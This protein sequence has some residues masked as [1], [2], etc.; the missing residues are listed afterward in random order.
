[1][2]RGLPA[3]PGGLAAADEEATADPA[4][5]VGDAFGAA[6][7]ADTVATSIATLRAYN[8]ADIKHL[9]FDSLLFIS[10]P[11]MSP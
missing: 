2:L 1:M 5:G 9:R 8:A 3:V 11:R 6:A 7:C 10:F 4:L